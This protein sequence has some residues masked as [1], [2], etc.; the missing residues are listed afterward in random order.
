MLLDRV[1]SYGYQLVSVLASWA[2]LT[3]TEGTIYP[4]LHRLTRLGYLDVDWHAS[5]S[6]PPRKYYVLNDHGRAFLHKQLAEW[7][8]LTTAVND[9][10]G[11]KYEDKGV[12]DESRRT[13]TVSR[14]AESPSGAAAGE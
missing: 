1:P 14:R 9:L 12:P 5:A 7:R 8:E 10:Y 11:Y 6:G 13:V 2:P 4:L 3:A